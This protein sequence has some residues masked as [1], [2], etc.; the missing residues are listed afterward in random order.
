MRTIIAMVLW[1]AMQNL[2]DAANQ[3]PILEEQSEAEIKAKRGNKLILQIKAKGEDLQY[4]WVQRGH[5][6]C[7]DAKCN[8]D[9][10]YWEL[11]HNDISVLV[12]NSVGSQAARFKVRLAEGGTGSETISPKLTKATNEVSKLMATDLYVRS[13]RGFVFVYDDLNLAI[14]GSEA[15]KTAWSGKLRT[16]KN[17]AGSFGWQNREQ[18]SVLAG[19]LVQLR[20]APGTREIEL[21]EGVLRS[22]SLNASTGSGWTITVAG[23]VQ[24]NGDEN[25]D[26]IVRR[27]STTSNE[28]DVVCL[29]GNCRVATS[30]LLEGDERRRPGPV[31]VLP[32]GKSVSILVENLPKIVHRAIDSELV[33]RIFTETTPYYL[34]PTLPIDWGRVQFVRREL[35][36]TPR[37][38]GVVLA[39]AAL[40]KLDGIAAL[41]AV[42]SHFGRIEKDVEV[43]EAIGRAFFLLGL[44]AD[45]D[46][47]LSAAGKLRKK[48]GQLAFMLGEARMRANRFEAAAEAFSDAIDLGFGDIQLTNYYRGVS[49]FGAG[50]FQNARASFVQAQWGGQDSKINASIREFIRFIDRDAPWSLLIGVGVGQDTAVY[51][52]SQDAVEQRLKNEYAGTVGNINL[53]GTYKFLRW[54]GGGFG[55]H[56]DLS[57]NFHTE[58]E[59]TSLDVLSQ[60]YGISFDTKVVVA[61]QT[62]I[63]FSI[64]TMIGA[65]MMHAGEYRTDDVIF[66]A[67]DLNSQTLIGQPRLVLMTEEH[68]DPFP[69]HD[70]GWDPAI[71]EVPARSER[72]HR[73][74]NAKLSSQPA[75]DWA[76]AWAFEYGA[77]HDLRRYRSQVAGKIYDYLEYGVFSQVQRR[78]LKKLELALEVDAAYKIFS[79]RESEQ[80]DRILTSNLELKFLYSPLWRQL[81]FVE[82]EVVDSNDPDRKFT[83]LYGGT[84]L[85]YGF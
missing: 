36:A 15:R 52:A 21:V 50:Q 58:P 56:A 5:I 46:R 70:D 1:F 24:V 80:A 28:V 32:A 34:K 39:K 8:F 47:P 20:D 71:R 84:S 59:Q 41:E 54:E 30:Q 16:Q 78:L 61:D 73:Y 7:T 2:A 81:L 12:Y 9:T 43:A 83:R 55:V 22:R 14:V 33:S 60:K 82:T 68:R 67:V 42:Y 79:R 4:A 25:G 10:Q 26:V 53:R 40:A 31:I 11:G 64:K 62:A 85:E 35:T 44:Y 18:H 57:R 51:R 29:R 17:S 49:Y 45:A 23:R 66:G 3:L 6:I 13:L 77:R 75:A 27:T 48:D 74:S 19:T 37:D 65:G 38:N 69:D 76:K 72:S 63:P